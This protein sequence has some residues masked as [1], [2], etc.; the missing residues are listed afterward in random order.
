MTNKE[1]CDKC[2]FS[3]PLIIGNWDTYC[4]KPDCSCHQDKMC[5]H[6]ETYRCNDPHCCLGDNPHCASCGEA[7]VEVQHFNI[8]GGGAH[9]ISDLEFEEE[10]PTEDVEE[11]SAILHAIY[12]KEARRQGDVRHHDDHKDLPENIKEFDRVLARFITTRERAAREALRE[13][14]VEQIE[15]V[16]EKE[17]LNIPD[18]F[19]RSLRAIRIGAFVDSRS[20]IKGTK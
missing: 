15:R 10:K 14:L 5:T 6:P 20:I 8:G 2:K 4:S 3:G 17:N 1:C 19:V 13:E 9:V 12:Q 7:I 11:L 18:S 16:I